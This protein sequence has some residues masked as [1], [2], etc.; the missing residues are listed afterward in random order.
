M[1]QFK[2]ALLASA[3]VLATSAA[4]AQVGAGANTDSSAAAAGSGSGATTDLNTRAAVRA[5]AARHRSTTGSAVYDSP[6]IRSN[7]VPLD[8]GAAS[9][10]AGVK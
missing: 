9:A 4:Y 3:L 10:G 2:T 1:K 6:R 5:D 7:S 8:D